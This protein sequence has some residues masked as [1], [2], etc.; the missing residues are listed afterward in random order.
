[1]TL[2]SVC[3][4]CPVFAERADCGLAIDDI[5]IP[6]LSESPRPHTD[7]WGAPK[8]YGRVTHSETMQL[9][10]YQILRD[11]KTSGQ[12]IC[13]TEGVQSGLIGGSLGSFSDSFQRCVLASRRLDAK[14]HQSSEKRR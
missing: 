8:D 13:L 10:L 14:V 1:M 9:A 2:A 11:L 12:R 7:D 3:V 4:V 6:L 5:N